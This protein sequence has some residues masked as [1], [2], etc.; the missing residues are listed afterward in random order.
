MQVLGK[1][2][3]FVVGGMSD[4]A[5]HGNEHNDSYPI[6]FE[7]ELRPIMAAANIDFRVRNMAMGGVPSYPGSMCMVDAFGEDADVIMWDFRMVERDAIKGELYIRQVK[8]SNFGVNISF[9]C[10]ERISPLWHSNGRTHTWIN[11]KNIMH[12]LPCI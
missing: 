3:V 7:S 1:S 5:G 4:T 12:P 2:F 9:I 6:V 10:F 11:S 8:P